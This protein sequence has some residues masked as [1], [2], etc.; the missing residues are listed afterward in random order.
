M[1]LSRMTQFTRRGVLRGALG[2]AGIGVVAAAGVGGYA[3]AIEP[4]LRLSITRYALRPPGWPALSPLRVAAIADLHACEPWL[5]MARVNQI[6]DATNALAPDL[7]VLLGDF[8]QAIHRFGT[9][10]VAMADWAGGLARLRA[11]LGRFAILGNHD[12]WTDAP[13]VRNALGVVGIPVLENDFVTLAT[14]GGTPFHLAGLADQL[15]HRIGFG[16]TMVTR[17]EDDLPGLRARLPEDEAPVILLAHE[18]DIFPFVPGRF[19]LTLS[20]HTHG[21]QV[22]LPFI[23]APIVP[24]R[25]GDRFAYGH[26]VEEGRHLIVSGGLGCTGVPVRLGVPPEIV[27]LELG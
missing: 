17:G 4:R 25:Y 12:W 26:I 11:P 24:S 5:P 19:S 16:R 10:P 14:P 6:V 15:A 23:G 13:G 27:L 8:V 7:V 22:R 1:P 21:G 18:P 3:F 9:R 20:G 2:L